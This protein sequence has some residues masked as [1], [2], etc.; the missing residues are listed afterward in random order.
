MD[1]ELS[2]DDQAHAEAEKEA[3]VERLQKAK[4]KVCTLIN[5]V[6]ER[7][8]FAVTRRSRRF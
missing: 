5:N 1:G 6:K 3:D 8:D 7:K 2:E 4:Q